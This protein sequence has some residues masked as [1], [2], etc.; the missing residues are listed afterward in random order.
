MGAKGTKVDDIEYLQR[1]QSLLESDFYRG[2][3]Y[4]WERR[5]NYGWQRRWSR[6][7]SLDRV[8]IVKRIPREVVELEK[9]QNFER[10]RP[11]TK[12]TSASVFE[13]STQTAAEQRRAS[14]RTVVRRHSNP[15]I[16]VF[17]RD[18]ELPWQPLKKRKRRQKLP[19]A[20]GP[21]Y[22]HQIA[23]PVI[24]EV[25]MQPAIPQKKER[26]RRFVPKKSTKKQEKPPSPFI[27]R[28]VPEQKMFFLS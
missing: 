19:M 10:P 23:I 18:P 11:V 1:K 16:S 2:P 14:Q 25:L 12:S 4:E 27:V 17:H 9:R 20:I 24:E 13:K 21:I 7:W 15:D 6:D 8:P 22:S 5:W 3:R 26:G 28:K